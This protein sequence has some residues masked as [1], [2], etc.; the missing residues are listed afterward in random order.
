MNKHMLAWGEVKEAA[1]ELLELVLVRSDEPRPA[2]LES[3][4]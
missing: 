2:F 4:L 3:K 1:D